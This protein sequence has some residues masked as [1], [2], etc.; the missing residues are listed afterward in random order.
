LKVLVTGAGGLVGRAVTSR[1]TSAGEDIVALDHRRLDIS[2]PQSVR[3]I[4]KD[5]RPDVVINCAAWTD[6][7]GCESDPAHAQA[8][9]GLGPELLASACHD[10]NALLITISTDY[11]F[12]GRKDGF[13]TQDDQP[14]PISVY[15]ESKLEGEQRAQAASQRTIV[16]RSGYIFGVGG[17]NFL[18]T[19]LARVRR[20]DSLK[21][22]SDM[23]GTPTYA[24]DLARGLY[25]LA[26]IDQPGIYHV[27]NA[28]DGVSFKGFADAALEMAGIDPNL[29]QSTTLAELNRPAPRPRNSRLHCLRSRGLGLEPLPDWR[30]ALADFVKAQT[31]ATQTAPSA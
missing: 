20:G 2:N 18:S 3:T 17:N 23:T 27:V 28:G 14:N 7:D 1:C 31:A 11:V 9:N 29:I 10:I 4:I 19:F 26:Q 21:A 13:Y 30:D 24:P 15:G 6:V 5:A 8:A 22:I 25:R 12:D 16:V